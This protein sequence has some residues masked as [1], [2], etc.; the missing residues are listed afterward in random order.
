MN[1]SIYV[2]RFAANFPDLPG[3]L[4]YSSW[5]QSSD[6]STFMKTAPYGPHSTTHSAIGGV[7]GCDTLDDMLAQGLITDSKAQVDICQKWGFWIKELYRG[8][9][10]TP[11]ADCDISRVSCRFECDTSKLGD[12]LDV[13]RYTVTLNQFVPD[14]LTDHQWEEWRDFVCTGDAYKI[15]VGD[16]L[17]S[18]S[19]SDP[20]FWPIHPTQERLVQVRT[21]PIFLPWDIWFTCLSFTLQTIALCLSLFESLSLSLSLSNNAKLPCVSLF[22]MFHILA[23]LFGLAHYVSHFILHYPIRQL[24][25]HDLVPC[26]ACQPVTRNTHSHVYFS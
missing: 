20:S 22:K 5:L 7:Y 3:C 21:L 19:P 15:F 17:E 10:I 24:V 12:M 1:P 6:F 8:Y 25:I 14:D 4:D 16:H 11:Q 13:L 23:Y 26:H 9:Y 2:T 18:A